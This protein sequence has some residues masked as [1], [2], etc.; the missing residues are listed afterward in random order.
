[1][2]TIENICAGYLVG[3][4]QYLRGG[5]ITS[6]IRWVEW[7]RDTCCRAREIA[8]GRIYRAVRPLIEAEYPK[9]K[10]EE[11]ALQANQ[12]VFREWEVWPLLRL[13]VAETRRFQRG[14]QRAGRR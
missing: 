3:C 11:A 13:Y 4:P 9:Q 6:M 10:I 8:E 12:G 7:S 2:P 1:M 14:P 5:A